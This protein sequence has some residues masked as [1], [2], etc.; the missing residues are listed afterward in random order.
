MEFVGGFEDV[1]LMARMLPMGLVHLGIEVYF[2]F[3]DDNTH[4]F[5]F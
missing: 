3:L 4:G 2:F 1:D 5:R